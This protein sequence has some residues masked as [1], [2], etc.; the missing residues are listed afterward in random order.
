MK[1]TKVMKDKLVLIRQSNVQFLRGDHLVSQQEHTAPLVSVWCSITYL[2]QTEKTDKKKRG[3]ADLGII[4][5]WRIIT[6]PTIFFPSSAASGEAAL[7]GLC[8]SRHVAQRLHSETRWSPSARA[9]AWTRPSSW[10]RRPEG[11]FMKMGRGREKGEGKKTVIINYKNKLLQHR[12]CNIVLTTNPR[13]RFGCINFNSTV[14][15]QHPEPRN[16]TRMQC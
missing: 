4:R 16:A 15:C 7:R 6:Q 9:P 10:R 14:N 1:T 13:L 12:I 5:K 8:W 11:Y 2:V 3:M